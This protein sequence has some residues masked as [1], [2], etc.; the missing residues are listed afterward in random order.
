[1]P[2]PRVLPDVLCS[3]LRAASMIEESS[4]RGKGGQTRRRGFVLT[5]F[6]AMGR[7]APARPREGAEYWKRN[8]CIGRPHKL[9]ADPRQAKEP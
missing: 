5:S 3:S 6:S 4:L 1:M 8:A 9:G 2:E 7:Q